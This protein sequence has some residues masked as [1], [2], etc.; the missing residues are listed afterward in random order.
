MGGYA[1]LYPPGPDRNKRQPDGQARPRLVQ[2]QGQMTQAVDQRK[3][4]DGL[5]FAEEGIRYEGAQKRGEIDRRGEAVHPD[6]GF[7]LVDFQAWQPKSHTRSTKAT[8]A[9]HQIFFR[10]DSTGYSSKN[11]QRVY[12]FDGSIFIIRRVHKQPKVPGLLRTSR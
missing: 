1:A 7:P 6:R 3:R 9:R 4:D 2:G 12:L 10:A 8:S 5:V 11:S